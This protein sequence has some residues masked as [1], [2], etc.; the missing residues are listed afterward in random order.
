MSIFVYEATGRKWYSQSE[1]G[2]EVMSRFVFADESAD[3]QQRR[4]ELLAAELAL[5]DQVERV[6]A[7]RRALPLG[8][9]V[10]DYVFREGPMDLSRNDPADFRDVRLADLFTDGHDTL[11]IDHLMF[12]AA[13]PEPCVMCSMW[14]DGYSAVTPHVMQRASF[15][16]VAKAE[17]SKLRGFA[18]QR[19]WDHI[20]LLSSHDNTFN[21][22]FGMENDDGT[23]NPGLSV[24]TRTPDGAVYHRYTIGAEFD[25]HNNRG[26]DPYSPVWNLFDLMPQGRGDWYPNHDYME[27]QVP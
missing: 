11:I 18:R 16:L 23:Q 19:G 3:Y 5:K 4:A 17:I 25:E 12:A 22:D 14:A 13:D 10:P 9:R 24:F 1:K 2:D 21:R 6:A 26:I 27:R 8:M 20:R 15:A 7:L